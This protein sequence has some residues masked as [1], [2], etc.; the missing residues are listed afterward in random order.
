MMAEPEGYVRVFAG[1]G[2]PMAALLTALDR[3]R[4]GWPYVHQVLDAAVQPARVGY[5]TG[6]TEGGRSGQPLPEGS[7]SR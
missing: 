4:P 5:A 6:A 1:E 7:S 2:Q 3:R